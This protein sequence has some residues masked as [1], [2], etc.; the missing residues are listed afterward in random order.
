VFVLN[1]ALLA[2]AVAMGRAASQR[3]TRVQ[4]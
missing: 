1:G 2:A 4:V 3:L